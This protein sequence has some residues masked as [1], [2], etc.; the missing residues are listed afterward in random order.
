MPQSAL[1]NGKERYN[2]PV[3]D[4]SDCEVVGPTDYEKKASKTRAENMFG[5]FKAVM[6]RK[7]ARE[8]KLD[9]IALVSWL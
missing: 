4:V 9:K 5:I 6:A 2:P 8:K 1:H 7:A 3:S